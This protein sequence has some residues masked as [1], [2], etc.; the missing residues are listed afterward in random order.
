MNPYDDIDLQELERDLVV[1]I[2]KNELERLA[3]MEWNKDDWPGFSAD[4]AES[5]LGLYIHYDEIYKP[6]AKQALWEADQKFIDIPLERSDVWTDEFVVGH[7]LAVTARNH[8]S[9][10][11]CPLLDDSVFIRRALEDRTGNHPLLANIG[12]VDEVRLQ[13]FQ[14]IDMEKHIR[15]SQF[16]TPND[17]AR[18]AVDI[19]VGNDSTAYDVLEPCDFQ[20]IAKDLM[21]SFRDVELDY[22]DY[23]EIDDRIA[24]AVEAKLSIKETRKV[25]KL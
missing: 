8:A 6:I 13:S 22:A 18:R 12:D 21:Y 16:C 10:D 11:I 14:S 2:A 24:A 5:Y 25:Q 9:A 17:I 23:E 20:R 7:A 1:R 15:S 3:Y 4:L 19:E